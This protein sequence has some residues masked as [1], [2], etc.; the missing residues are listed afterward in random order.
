MERSEIRVIVQMAG[1][2]RIA[3]RSIRATRLALPLSLF[4]LRRTSRLAGTTA[5]FI[6]SSRLRL[7]AMRMLID[8]VDDLRPHRDRQPLAHALYHQEFGA[9]YRRRGVPTALCT[10]TGIDGAGD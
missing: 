10:H 2:S 4:E 3:L 8:P 9:G 5:I 7:R 6:R 1:W